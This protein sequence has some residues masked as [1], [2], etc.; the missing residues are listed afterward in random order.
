[1]VND[2]E[3]VMGLAILNNKQVAAK[4]SLCRTSIYYLTTA[5]KFPKPIK[6]GST[7]RLGWIESEVEQWIAEQ[8]KATRGMEAA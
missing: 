2:K 4:T 3:K 8:I 1:M 6:L 5:G 7:D